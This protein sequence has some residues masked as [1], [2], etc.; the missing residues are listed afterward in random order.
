MPP[1][2]SMIAPCIIL[3]SDP[4]QRLIVYTAEPD[5]PTAHALPLLAGYGVDSRSGASNRTVTAG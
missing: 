5:S 3:A 2:T 4:E 1:S